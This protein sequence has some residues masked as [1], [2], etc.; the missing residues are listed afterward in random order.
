MAKHDLDSAYRRL[1]WHAKCA[2]LCI[3]VIA[4][5]A[6]LLTRLCFGIASGQSKWCVIWKT[7][8]DF[9]NILINDQSWNPR[10]IFNPK[11]EIPLIT[12]YENKKIPIREVTTGK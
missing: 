9:A 1:H 11:K 3:T 2:L 5:T 4:N 8:I 12:T 10:D 6:Y 7:M